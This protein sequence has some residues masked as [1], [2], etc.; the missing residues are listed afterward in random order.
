MLIYTHPACLQHDPGR[1]HAESPQ[2]LHAVLD[3]LRGLPQERMEWREAP[4][5]SRDQLAMAHTR[6][7]LDAVLI[8]PLSFPHQL[9]ADTVVSEGSAQA[10]LLAVGAVLGAVDAICGEHPDTPARQAFCAVRPP[11]HH[12]TMST[13][14]GFCLFNAVAV[15]ARQAVLIHGME[16][17]AIVDFDVHHGN[18]TQAIVEHDPRILYLSSHQ[19]PLYPDSGGADERG[20]GNVFNAPLPAG[21]DGEAFRRAWRET[22]LPELD[23]FQPQLILVS[24]GF[25][26]HW[27]DPLAGLLLKE[28]DYAWIAREL[29]SAADQHCGG[30]LISTLEG[31]YSLSALGSSAAAY[32]EAQLSR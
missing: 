32:V 24:A 10:A 17:V 20:V 18:G 9:D 16:R 3:A 2:R 25:D 29:L 5:A 26:G 12:A 31:G 14:M 30:R 19:L 1:A 11:G 22:L 13:P 8:E 28:A 21:A 15:A 6:R 27:L 7:L 4:A 23:R